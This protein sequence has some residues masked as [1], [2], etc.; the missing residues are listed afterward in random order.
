MV[1]KFVYYPLKYLVGFNRFKFYSFVKLLYT[2][3]N[4]VPNR[5]NNMNNVGRYRLETS[6]GR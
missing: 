2:T 4:P 1:V 5:E 6:I 3:M